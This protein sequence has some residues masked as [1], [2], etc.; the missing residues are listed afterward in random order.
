VSESVEL[1]PSLHSVIHSR[2]RS[3]ILDCCLVIDI[4]P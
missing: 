4:R 2:S 1:H 3:R